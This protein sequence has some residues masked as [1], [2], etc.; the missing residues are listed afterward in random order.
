MYRLMAIR[1][2]R[3]ESWRGVNP[4]AGEDARRPHAQCVRGLVMRPPPA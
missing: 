2:L 4:K 1:V 3:E